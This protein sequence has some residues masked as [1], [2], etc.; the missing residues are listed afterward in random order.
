MSN[1]S[2]GN[3]GPFPTATTMRPTFAKLPNWFKALG[4]ARAKT[5]N[6][7][8]FLVGDST[9]AGYG[10]AGNAGIGARPGNYPVA[11]AANMAAEGVSI[12]DG[13]FFSD[14][15]V[16]INNIT[17]PQYDPR[18]VFGSGWATSSSSAVCGS[19]IA[20]STTTNAV[21]FTPA[22]PFDTLDIYYFTTGGG[23]S[24]SVNVDGGA[25]IGTVN[26]NAA[27]SISKTTFTCPLG[28]HTINIARVSGGCYLFGVMAYNSAV[29]G[30]CMF[31]LGSCG[32]KAIDFTNTNFGSYSLPALSALC[33][34]ALTVINLTINDWIQGTALA[35]YTA[36]LQS[37]ITT[38]K[39]TGDA[40][41]VTGAPSS[42]ATTPAATQ[43]S[44]IG[45]MQSLAATNNVPLLDFHARWE[46]YEALQ[47]LGFYFDQVHPVAAGYNDLASFL[48]NSLLNASTL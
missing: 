6:A 46:S 13:G 9:T 7:N 1:Y 16:S 14:Q 29:K 2:P 35:A 8:L 25:T 40:V 21:S 37:I 18:L 11:F 43:L 24:A 19:A 47:S 38:A 41:L 27:A 26:F 48:S 28:N 17:G 39:L 42:V 32:A 5:A 30:L 34:P 44:Y 12:V 4:Q 10:A 36:Q 3:V 22:V 33:A 20:N 15:N 23:G 45:A 31:Q